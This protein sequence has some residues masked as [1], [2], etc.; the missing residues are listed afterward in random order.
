M[1]SRSSRQSGCALVM[2]CAGTP[3]LGAPA[4]RGLRARR[5]A[6]PIGVW[7]QIGA[8]S[9]KQRTQH[10]TNHLFFRARTA[11]GLTP[12]HVL[13]GFVTVGFQAEIPRNEMYSFIC[14]MELKA[15]RIS[16]EYTFFERNQAF[17]LG[18]FSIYLIEHSSVFNKIRWRFSLSQPN[19][20]SCTPRIQK[21][22]KSVCTISVKVFHLLRIS[23]DEQGHRKVN[24]LRVVASSHQVAVFAQQ[25]NWIHH[26]Q[27]TIS[28][29]RFSWILELFS[30][31][32][33]RDFPA[34]NSQG[35]S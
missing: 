18:V 11:S 31:P 3:A 6:W 7:G 5:P 21:P 29:W 27:S 25:R 22:L 26:H 17:S 28:S 14:D 35:A 16:R 20:N 24:A 30:G 1:A 34:S 23:S 10:T 32:A 8:Y 15:E 13:H 19:K 2:R 12:A 33:C 9:Y 4:R